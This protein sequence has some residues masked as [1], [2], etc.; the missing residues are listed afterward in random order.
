[1][2]LQGGSFLTLMSKVATFPPSGWISP[3]WPA[4]RI[5]RCFF[6]RSCLKP[7]PPPLWNATGAA[8]VTV[9]AFELRVNSPLL[10]GLLTCIS[11]IMCFSVFSF[12]CQH[13]P[14]LSIVMCLSVFSLTFHFFFACQYSPL[15]YNSPA[16]Q[17][18]SLFF[19]AHVL[20]SVIPC[21]SVFSSIVSIHLCLS[22]Y[23][24]Y[25]RL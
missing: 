24:E 13:S 3:L 12:D 8:R 15:L 21:R 16:C 19:N 4:F 23:Y 1:M 18:S 2:L 10:V 14:L 22:A 6:A 9:A 11:I 25:C 17:Y 7:V 5:F 20:V